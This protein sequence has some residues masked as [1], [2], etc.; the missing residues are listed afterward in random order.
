MIINYPYSGN[1]KILVRVPPFLNVINTRMGL[2]RERFMEAD[3]PTIPSVVFLKTLLQELDEEELLTVDPDTLL[4]RTRGYVSQVAHKF[5]FIT[6]RKTLDRSW[7]FE[8]GVKEY[9]IP[10]EGV[11][12]SKISHIDPWERW[13]SVKTVKLLYVDS[14]E[15]NVEDYGDVFRYKDD[16]PEYAVIA[17]DI[18][19]LLL[20]Y[21]IYLREH[22]LTLGMYEVAQH[23]CQQQVALLIEDRVEVWVTNWLNAIMTGT[24]G[25]MT[26]NGTISTSQFDKATEEIEDLVHRLENGSV[27]FADMFLTRFYGTKNISD[28]SKEYL[29]TYNQGFGRRRVAANLLAIVGIGSVYLN[30]LS[31]AEHKG[32]VT[33]FIRRLQIDYRKIKRSGW[34]HMIPDTFTKLTIE[35]MLDIIQVMGLTTL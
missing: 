8:K 31:H 20:K 27:K 21:L 19:A 15:L 32:T 17:I 28:V 22:K 7:F 10:T 6:L 1:E 4:D 33:Q 12:G 2:Y 26:I 23:F 11:V 30:L 5:D 29:F 24:E 34:D 14:N 13:K 18:L 25:Q 9:I 3:L 35:E 16:K